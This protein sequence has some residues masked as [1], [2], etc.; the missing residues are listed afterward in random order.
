MCFNKDCPIRLACK[1][2]YKE[3]FHKD[4]LA[5]LLNFDVIPIMYK[6]AFAGYN[7]LGIEE[8]IAKLQNYS[9]LLK[10]H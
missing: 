3:P 10:K 9:S 6:T 2:C 4:H 7:K 5:E 1:Y 8:R